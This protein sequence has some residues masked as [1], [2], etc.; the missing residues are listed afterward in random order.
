VGLNDA[1]AAAGTALAELQ[2]ADPDTLEALLTNAN[3]AHTRAVGDLQQN[4][5]LSRE[6]Q[7]QL[8]HETERGPAR[9]HDEAISLLEQTRSELERL[10]DRAAAAALL[11]KVFS[12][13]RQQARHRYAKPFRDQIETLGRIAYEGGFEIALDDDLSIATRTLNGTTLA[14]EQLSTGAQEQLGLLA[15]LACATLVA[16][17]GGAPVIF[18]DALGW[19]DPQR[20]ARM[21][22]AIATAANDC[23]VIILTCVPDRYAAVGNARTVG[24]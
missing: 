10:T 8:R 7:I 5:T 2:K 4:R 23:Q 22:A 20:L 17:E 24:M 1:K 6:L 21:G 9:D 18:D 11:H 14:F 12:E 13:H 19:T 16:P 15:R 3:N